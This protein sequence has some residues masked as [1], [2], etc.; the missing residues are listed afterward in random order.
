MAHEHAY[1]VST[2]WTAGQ[3]G[4]AQSDSAL[5]AIH[6]SEPEE[7]GGIEGRWT[8]E[9][10]LLCALAGCFTTTFQEEARTAKFLYIDLEVEAEGRGSKKKWGCSFNEIV[11]RPRL[12]V[13][14]EK[15]LEEGMELL[16]R[17]QSQC[18]ISYAIS[19]TQMMEPRVEVSKVPAGGWTR[20]VSAN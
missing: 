19:V 11:L 6:F 18:P 3:T 12:T 10:L 4:L 7:R 5:S 13:S 9:Q 8:P 20:E 17:A 15:Q 16:R 14:S 2:W 1:R